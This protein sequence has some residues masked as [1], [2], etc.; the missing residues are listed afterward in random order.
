MDFELKFRKALGLNL[1]EIWQIFFL[2]PQIFM[3]LGSRSPVWNLVTN[4]T[5]DDE[6]EVETRNFLTWSW[7]FDSKLN[8][9]SFI[10]TRTWL[11]KDLVCG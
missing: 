7:R 6:F 4:S 2:G 3:K 10:S 9:I 1:K 5:H 8:Q 11:T